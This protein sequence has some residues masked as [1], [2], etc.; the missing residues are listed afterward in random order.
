MRELM[1]PVRTRGGTS[2]VMDSMP[3]E[4]NDLDDNENIDRHLTVCPSDCVLQ[5]NIDHFR[6]EIDE[7]SNA[8]K[9]LQAHL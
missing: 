7:V 8:A 5:T 1:K 4:G 9:I 2:S 6:K 3:C